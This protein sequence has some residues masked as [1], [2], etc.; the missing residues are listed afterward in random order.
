MGLAFQLKSGRTSAPR[1]P[2]AERPDHLFRGTM[3]GAE[4]SEGRVQTTVGGKFGRYSENQTQLAT[5]PSKSN[6]SFASLESGREDP[7]T[8]MV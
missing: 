1:L 8:A 5:A 4:L 2:Q 7:S 6:G 3:R